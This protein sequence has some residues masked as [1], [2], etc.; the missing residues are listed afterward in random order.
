VTIASNTGSADE[1]SSAV[2]FEVLAVGQENRAPDEMRRVED[3]RE[4]QERLRQD[5]EMLAEKSVRKKY[6]AESNCDRDGDDDVE[7]EQDPL[8]RRALS[9]GWPVP[10]S[11]SSPRRSTRT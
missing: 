8:G 9:R 6:I 11:F 3:Q 2:E 1:E 10:T 7:E 5:W 4:N